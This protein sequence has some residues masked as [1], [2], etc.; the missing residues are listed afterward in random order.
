MT[1]P[2]RLE[3]DLPA[4][5][6]ELYVTGTP[7]YRDDLVRQIAA[8]RQR[9]AWTFP[10]RW[11]PM[12]I[13][14]PQTRVPGVPL[15]TIGVLALIAVLIAAALAVYV[16]SR[17]RLPEPFG[18]AANGQ[19]AYARDG[20][21]YVR[22]A[23][24]AAPRTLISGPDVETFVQYSP[25]GDRL[26]VFRAVDGGEEAW[27]A[28]ADGTDLTRIGGPWASADRVEWSPDQ[29]YLAVASS[30]NGFPRIDLVATDGSGSRPLAD[31]P[32]MAP[33][34]R[35]P[36]G[37][38]ILFRGQRDGR[39]SFY[40]AD[41]AGG[42]PVRV[43]IA[44]EN[45]AG[46]DY[47]LRSPAWSPTGDRLAFDSLV[48]LP[49]S[50]L[51]TDGLRIHT[52]SVGPAGEISGLRR[53]E[54]DPRADDEL[55]PVFTPDGSQIIFQQRFGPTPADPTGGVPTID[56]LHIAPAD[57]SGP[58]RSLGISSEP[59]EGFSTVVAPDGT[60]LIVRLFAE[61][62]DWLVDPVSGT[63]TPTD[64]ASTFGAT[65]QRRGR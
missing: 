58:A 63:A 11:L 1:T 65:W 54:F 19:I 7:D 22:D 33:T 40:L 43:D 46:G 64:F 10:E 18:P 32:A 52:A 27:V 61:G 21:V 9:P 53:L 14:S 15:R 37:R 17:P 2:Q 25:L 49:G 57:G 12:D 31:F 50:E 20:V 56:S 13:T 51:G 47:D 5:L 41:T 39:W 42:A 26:A 44:G 34:F 8:T 16:G 3:R 38:Q 28:D 30:D 45:L 55:Y 59:G 35:P 4:V 24:D 6:A 36:D 23:P 60:S 62:E 29:A 48:A